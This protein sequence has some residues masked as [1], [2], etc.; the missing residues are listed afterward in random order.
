[1]NREPRY[2]PSEQPA[3]TAGE[4]SPAFFPNESVARV[5]HEMALEC[6]QKALD[7]AK[8][9]SIR[10]ELEEEIRKLVGQRSLWSLGSAPDRAHSQ[11]RSGRE[12][13]APQMK[14]PGLGALTGRGSKTTVEDIQRVVSCEKIPSVSLVKQW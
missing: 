7:G 8:T 3:K 1:M 13:Q 11:E 2:S 4:Q 10:L 5:R 9:R 12:A 6:A 14:S